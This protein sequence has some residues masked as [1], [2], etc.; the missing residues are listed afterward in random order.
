[1]TSTLQQTNC[2]Q[3]H[4]AWHTWAVVDLAVEACRHQDVIELT[5]PPQK[6]TASQGL[7][8]HC[9]EVLSRT[10]ETTVGV[11]LLVQA[12]WLAGETRDLSRGRSEL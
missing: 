3:H 12:V 9:T 7:L 11:K 2:V 5:R 10:Q 6:R 4:Q 1:M 8:G